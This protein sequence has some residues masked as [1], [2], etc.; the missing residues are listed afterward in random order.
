MGLTM[1]LIFR[2]IIEK[3]LESHRAPRRDRRRD[4]M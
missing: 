4:R 2:P 1:E 3:M